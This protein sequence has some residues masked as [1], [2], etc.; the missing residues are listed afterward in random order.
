M[1]QAK[2]LGHIASIDVCSPEPTNIQGL[3]AMKEP[4]TKRQVRRFLGG[5]H[6]YRKMWRNRSHAL[7]PLTALTGNMNF[8]WNEK[9]QKAFEETKAIMSKETMLCYPNCELPFLMF[10]DASDMQLGADVSQTQNADIAYTNVEETLKEDHCPVLLHSR[11]L[12][13]YQIN[14]TVTDKEL[15]SV[16]DALV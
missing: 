14:Y 9:H 4:K 10:P 5:I 12:N 6:F 1:T 2:H 13:N 8:Q 16:V 3:V 7:V 15:L 11:K